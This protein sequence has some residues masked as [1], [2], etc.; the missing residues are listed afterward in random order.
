MKK[1]ISIL[2]ILIG[3]TNLSSIPIYSQTFDLNSVT[4]I[5]TLPDS[6]SIGL[7]TTMPIPIDTVRR[8]L[9]PVLNM[10]EYLNRWRNGDK[11][12]YV[13]I[14]QICNRHGKFLLYS[15]KSKYELNLIL[16]DISKKTTYP[17]SLVIQRLPV[18]KIHE[19]R[20]F[21]R[22]DEEKNYIEL[23][24]I[25]QFADYPQICLREYYLLEPGFPRVGEKIFRYKDYPEEGVPFEPF[26]SEKWM[27]ISD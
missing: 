23:N 1:F 22:Y 9:I 24:T 15:C 5:E 16:A 7:C 19:P 12:S 6:V 2:L 27:E 10:T 14:Y 13:A 26:N 3:Y 4:R 17:P 11:L 20:I 18:S 8:R 25:S 21:Y